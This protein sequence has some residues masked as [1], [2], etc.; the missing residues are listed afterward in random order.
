[1]YIIDNLKIKILINIDIICSKEIT[2]NLQTR[3]FIIDNYDITTFITCT[4][5]DFKINRI[6]KSH[7]IVIISTYTIMTILFKTQ[8]VE[9]FNEK[10]YSFQLHFTSFDFETKND[11]IIYIINVKTF[12]INVKTFVIHVQNATNKSLIVFKYIKLDKIFDFEK[13][14]YCHVNSTLTFS[15]REFKRFKST[16]S[17]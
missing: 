11:I 15:F 16:N 8:N 2:T 17:I 1:M 14:N 9:L 6:V 10:N 12:V 7:Y 5:V 3:K 4:F 13:K